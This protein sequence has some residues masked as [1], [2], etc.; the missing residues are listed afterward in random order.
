MRA[1]VGRIFLY[2]EHLDTIVSLYQ[3]VLALPVKSYEP[4]HALALETRPAPIVLNAPEAPWYSPPYEPAGSGVLLWLQVE[5]NLE[6]SALS[7]KAQDA[8]L[9]TPVMD[10]ERRDLLLLRDPEGRRVG[11]NRERIA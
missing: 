3:D 5:E 9:L 6:E 10:G 7:L 8:D 4:G 11:L 1:V 2:T